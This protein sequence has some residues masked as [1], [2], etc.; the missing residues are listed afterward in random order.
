MAAIRFDLVPAPSDSTPIGPKL[1]E[2]LERQV[3]A[4]ARSIGADL[5]LTAVTDPLPPVEVRRSPRGTWWLA[6]TSDADPVTLS[7]DGVT[8]APPE[9]V[10]RLRR[11]RAAGVDFD[12]IYILHELPDTWTPGTP[13]PT[14]QLAGNRNVDSASVARLQE[15]TFTAG[16][17]AARVTA[18]MLGIAARGALMAGTAMAGAM[19]AAIVYDPVV[20]GGIQDPESGRIA[21]VTLAAWD[22]VP[23]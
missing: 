21:W 15:A 17:G 23:R 14:M 11:L 6:A 7:N 5:P 16:L 3:F 1:A 2:R 13:P 4:P 10:D 19:A 20:L 12:Y 9:V 18:K 22:E 8:K